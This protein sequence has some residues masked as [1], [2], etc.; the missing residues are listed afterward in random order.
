M[1]NYILKDIFGKP[2]YTE[3]LKDKVFLVV[4]TASKWGFTSQ[5][6]ALDELY[7]KYKDKN[8]EVL[9]FPCNQF[10]SQ[11]PLSNEDIIVV[12][13]NEYNVSYKI[14]EKTNVNGENEN[15]L[16]TDLKSKA[17][18]FLSNNIK[19]NFTKFLVS[20]NADKVLRYTP[21][22]KIEKIEKDIITLL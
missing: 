4:N 16:F 8:F 19:W 10:G 12:Y 21:N 6:K 14:F 17:K 22:A 7:R 9:A 18:G 13:K 1:Y 11:E 20:K 15:P 3:T 2:F 5:L